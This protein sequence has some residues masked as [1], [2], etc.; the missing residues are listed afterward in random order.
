MEDWDL[1]NSV[2]VCCRTNICW[3]HLWNVYFLSVVYN[4]CTSKVVF[5]FPVKHGVKCLKF[6]TFPWIPL[7]TTDRHV[8]SSNERYIKWTVFLVSPSATLNWL[9][10]FVAIMLTSF[11][12]SFSC[13][14]N[15]HWSVSAHKIK[16]KTRIPIYRCPFTWWKG[17]CNHQCEGKL[18]SN[19]RDTT[20]NDSEIEVPS[21][22]CW[23]QLNMF[24]LNVWMSSH[25]PDISRTVLWV[26]QI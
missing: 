21:D 12:H 20:E 3:K 8:L 11:C 5:L 7:T 15:M 4:E 14:R 17:H 18:I 1:I 16:M 24:C 23:R 13:W 6:S 22:L 26:Y 9:N 25:I 19:S 10:K 2:S